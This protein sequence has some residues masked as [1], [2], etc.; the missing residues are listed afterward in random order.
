MLLVKAHPASYLRIRR[1]DGEGMWGI[2]PSDQSEVHKVPL[3]EPGRFSVTMMTPMASVYGQVEKLFQ[4]FGD[5]DGADEIDYGR[6]EG[7]E[8]TPITV[9]DEPRRVYVGPYWLEWEGR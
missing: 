5:L 4:N 2:D 1:M 6:C 7:R 9:C 8:R 3:E